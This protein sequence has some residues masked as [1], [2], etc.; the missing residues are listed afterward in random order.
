MNQINKAAERLYIN[1]TN[2]CNVQCDFC[3]MF[4]SPDKNTFL[5]FYKFKEVI[6][7]TIGLF[8]IQLE[9]GEPL[10]HKDLYL[11]LEYIRFTNRCTKITISTNGILLQKNI[12]RL[13]DFGS[14]SNIPITIKRSINYYLYSLDNFIFKKCRDLYLATEFIPNFKIEFNVRILKDDS[15]IIT[16]LKEHKIFEYSNVYKLQNYGRFEDSSYNKPFIVRNI[17]KFNLYASDGT[18][19]Y[20]NMIARSEYEKT[21]L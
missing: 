20:E 1:I 18:C 8:E 5:S 16:Q 10:L 15:F 13:T 11:F 14:S 7:S 3:C 6:D 2:K 17:E 19:F 21:L 4:S 12:Q 9:G